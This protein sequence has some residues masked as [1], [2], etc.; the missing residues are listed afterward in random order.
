MNLS[1]EQ[2]QTITQGAVTVEANE[3][4]FRFH[5]FTKE[6]QEVYNNFPLCRFTA[7]IK[8]V[9]K[10]DSTHLCVKGHSTRED[11]RVAYFLDCF[12]FFVNGE[13]IC[14]VDNCA[15]IELPPD[16]TEFYLPE[17]N[18]SKEFELT[19]GDKVIEIHLP[20]ASIGVIEEISIDD[21]AS[22]VPIK[23]SKKLLA[24][25]D[26][27]THGSM[28]R[29]PSDRYTAKLANALDAEEINKGIGGDCFFPA[30]ASTP[31][32]F[33]PNYITVA[34]GTND[35]YSNTR[36]E[37]R[38]NCKDF[39]LKLHA[40]YPNTMIFAISPIWRSDTHVEK[41][42]GDFSLIFED[43][44]ELVSDIENVIYID[45]M[46]L[47]PHNTE[48]FGDLSVHP[49]SAGFEYYYNNLYDE[50]KKYL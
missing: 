44:K 38:K 21:G 48:L 33:T 30:I 37:F 6:Q 14:S 1:L 50:L 49:N 47:I 7:G 5:R 31:D 28:A 3:D 46:D 32:S 13:M 4:G 41:Q 11:A 27:I 12:D 42:F 24:F 17:I 16:L 29:H 8:L 36:T 2:I 23:P 45:G 34:Y 39:F 26:S 19:K 25:G 20:Y 40:S 43:I 22:L 35:W 9:F 15:D 10:T 18:F